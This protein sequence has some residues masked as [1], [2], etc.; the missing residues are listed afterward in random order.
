ML[1]VILYFHFPFNYSITNYN[2][3][4]FNILNI[5]EAIIDSCVRT[6]LNWFR[7]ILDNIRPNL[8]NLKH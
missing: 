2:V 4:A 6:L 5:N 3:F 1:F 7:T 8:Q